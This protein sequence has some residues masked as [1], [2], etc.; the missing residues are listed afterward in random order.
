MVALPG[1]GYMPAK[2]EDE[3]EAARAFCV[4]AIWA[5]QLLVIGVGCDSEFGEWL[6]QPD[7]LIIQKKH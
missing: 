1:V 5:T 4:A 3:R 6:G 7:G 2:G